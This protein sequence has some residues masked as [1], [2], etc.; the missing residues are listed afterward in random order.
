MHFCCPHWIGKEW[1]EENLKQVVHKGY[2]S[3]TQELSEDMMAVREKEMPCHC[4]EE[5]PLPLLIE[6]LVSR[7]SPLPHRP[8]SFYLLFCLSCLC[9]SYPL[10][11]IGQRVWC[12]THCQGIRRLASK[13]KFFYVLVMWPCW[14]IHGQCFYVTPF[15][16][17]L[18]VSC[19]GWLL[20]YVCVCAHARVC[21]HAHMRARGSREYKRW[22]IKR[23]GRERQRGER[24]GERKKEAEGERETERGRV[25]RGDYNLPLISPL[26]CSLKKTQIFICLLT[27][28]YA[29]N[30]EETAW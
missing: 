8:W 17:L 19:S 30:R 13:L 21:T 2:A 1:N 4:C 25:R 9:Y 3:C 7:T 12:R 22:E 11:F 28:Y 29:V 27:T 14:V 10:L 20:R 15:I 5:K 6:M 24:E 18:V 23:Q 16:P 26:I